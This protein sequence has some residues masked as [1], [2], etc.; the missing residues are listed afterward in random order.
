MTARLFG[1]PNCDTVKKARAWLDQSGVAYSF[2]DIRQPPIG[3][4]QVATWYAA[5]GDALVNT[6]STSYRQLSQAER[7]QIADGDSL[8]VL[9]RYP[10]LIKRPVLQLGQDYF[11]GFSA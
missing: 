3:A 5:L 8:A 9:Q 11:C 4:E 7:T 6:R 10:T 2:I 1:I